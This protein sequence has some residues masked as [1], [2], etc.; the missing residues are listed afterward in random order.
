VTE[1][2]I[3]VDALRRR[4]DEDPASIVLADCRFELQ[5]AEA[6]RRA[7]AAGHLP[8]AWYLHLDEDLSAPRGAVGGRHPLP[9]AEAFGRTM[10]RIGLGRDTT[11]VAYDDGSHAFAARLWWLA[12]HFGHRDSRVLDGGLAAW[13]RAGGEQSRDL[14]VAAAGDFAPERRPEDIIDYE[15]VR[16]RDPERV[17]LVDSRDPARYAGEQEPI[18]P[19]A[20]HIPGAVNR[21]W[22]G[23]VGDDG[24]L[25]DAAVQRARWQDLVGSREP[26]VYCGSGVTACLNI[27]SLELAGYPGARLYPGS[28]SDWC[29]RG[30]EVATGPDP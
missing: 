19:F 11:L 3:D 25:L 15:A 23:A 5:D 21:P 4:I 22:T 30:G 14:P 24:R 2:L 13:C 26:V 9:D 27:L 20:G 29:Q 18:D 6:G 28:W 10:R 8:G 17:L 1:H 12:R 16:S 7:Y